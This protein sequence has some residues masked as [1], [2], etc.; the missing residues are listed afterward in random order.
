MVTASGGLT[1]SR[2]WAETSRSSSAGSPADAGA[3]SPVE[4]HRRPGPEGGPVD[5]S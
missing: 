3:C 5:A 4:A 2:R 1:V